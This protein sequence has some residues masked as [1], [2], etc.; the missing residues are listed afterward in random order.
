MNWGSD[1]FA[2]NEKLSIT[3]PSR[4]SGRALRLPARDPRGVFPRGVES[5]GDAELA[6]EIPSSW[7]NIISSMSHLWPPAISAADAL[8][9]AERFA[10]I[11]FAL[12]YADYPQKEIEANGNYTP[13]DGS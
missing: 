2:P 3:P 6:G 9:P 11:N 8:L 12:G 13:N 7:A 10:A 1:L 4:T 5:A